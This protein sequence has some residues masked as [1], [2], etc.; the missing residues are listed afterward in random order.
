MAFFSSEYSIYVRHSFQVANSEHQLSTHFG[1][2]KI[3]V[4]LN[5]CVSCNFPF[6]INLI[7]YVL[8][9]MNVGVILYIFKYSFVLCSTF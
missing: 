3:I 1:F 7:P 8:G 2:F 4:L 5:V 6:M 9:V